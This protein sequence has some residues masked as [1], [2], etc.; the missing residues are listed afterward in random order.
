[1]DLRSQL[2]NDLPRQEVTER[3]WEELGLSELPSP[4]IAFEESE[5]EKI[6]PMSIQAPFEEREGSLSE[7]YNPATVAP[8]DAENFSSAIASILPNG[9]I[10]PLDLGTAVPVSYTHLTL[11]TKRIV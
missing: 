5:R 1:M 4:L 9:G 8:Q 2:Y 3:M 6:G 11:P 10:E 7:W